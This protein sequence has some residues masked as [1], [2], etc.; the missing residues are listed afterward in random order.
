MQEIARITK[1]KNNERL[2]KIQRA[3]QHQDDD[4]NSPENT[5]YYSLQNIEE[6]QQQFPN[7]YTLSN[8]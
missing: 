4:K 3:N 8:I 7:T 6:I 5:L 2:I 1:D